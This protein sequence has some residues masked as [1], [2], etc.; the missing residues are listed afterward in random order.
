LKRKRKKNLPDVFERV[1]VAV[2]VVVVTVIEGGGGS[3]K[4]KEGG[5]RGGV[6]RWRLG[7]SDQKV[8]P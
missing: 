7:L 3:G 6:S 5:E 2:V 8:K 4:R 1:E